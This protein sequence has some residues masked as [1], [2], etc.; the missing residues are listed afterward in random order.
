MINNV[1][2]DRVELPTA[3]NL[4]DDKT[5]LNVVYNY[6]LSLKLTNFG[7]IIASASEKY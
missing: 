7:W 4:K 1:M 3:R 5:F 6:V 2:N